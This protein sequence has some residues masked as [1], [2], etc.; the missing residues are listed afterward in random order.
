MGSHLGTKGKENIIKGQQNRRPAVKKVIELFNSLY[1]EFKQKYPDQ[2]LSDTHE[3]PLD[4]DTFIKWGMDH[5]FWNDGLYYH[6]DAPWSTNPDVQAGIHCILL[7]GR[8]QEE[9]GIIGQEL[10]RTVGWG[11]ERFSQITE[12]VNNITKRIGSIRNDPTTTAD[13]IDNL[14]LGS[15]SRLEKLDLIKHEMKIELN[16]HGSLLQ[17]WDNDIAWLWS[18]C[19]PQSSRPLLQR[20]DSTLDRI[21]RE[22]PESN[23][24]PLLL[25]E[26]EIE[27]AVLEVD[28][29]DGEDVAEETIP[30]VGSDIIAAGAQ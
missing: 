24:L 22:E 23:S 27:D 20:W 14:P 10:A 25:V 2:H 19:Q 16:N 18:R 29:D 4:Y 1:T 6:T 8:V 12:T 28:H 17:D 30:D 3:H 26:D 13:H 5:S 15:M 21:R 7:L 11:V 9:F